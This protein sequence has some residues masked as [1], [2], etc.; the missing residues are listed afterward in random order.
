MELDL[1][2]IAYLLTCD[3]LIQKLKAS[4]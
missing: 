1:E 3:E 2:K 4:S